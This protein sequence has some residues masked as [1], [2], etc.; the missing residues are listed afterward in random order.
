M[1]GASPF[2]CNFTSDGSFWENQVR[3]DL[4]APTAINSMQISVDADT[5]SCD[6]SLFSIQKT[7]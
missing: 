2:A 1:Q 4:T 7:A 6:W 5:W 3:A